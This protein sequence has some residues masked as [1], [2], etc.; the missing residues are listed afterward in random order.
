LNWIS[1]S[2]AALIAVDLNIAERGDTVPLLDQLLFV[3]E[4]TAASCNLQLT[5]LTLAANFEARI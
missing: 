3:C 2:G 1:G 4:R 5:G